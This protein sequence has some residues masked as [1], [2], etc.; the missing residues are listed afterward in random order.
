MGNT[1]GIVYSMKSDEVKQILNHLD[2]KI[3]ELKKEL[4]TKNDLKQINKNVADLKVTIKTIQKR[5]EEVRVDTSKLIIDTKLM[6]MKIANFETTLEIIQIDVS[7]M[8]EDLDGM[9]DNV[10]EILQEMI[11]QKEFERLEKR[12]ENLEQN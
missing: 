1:N 5:L 12:V 3:E 11:T 9:I 10:K 7:K 6:K 2:T 4:A 8:K